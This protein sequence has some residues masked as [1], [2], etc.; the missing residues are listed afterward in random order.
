[1]IFFESELK[2][3]AKFEKEYQFAK[4]KKRLFRFDYCFTD[5][6]LAIEVEGGIW[7]MGGHNRPLHFIKDMEKYNLATELGFHLLRYEPKNLV[8]NSTL[9]QIKKV[10]DN[11]RH[12]KDI[13]GIDLRVYGI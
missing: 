13:D 12:Q 2:K 1:M 8:K 11:L 9:N 4:E 3:I 5:V 6:K 7:Q 10:Y